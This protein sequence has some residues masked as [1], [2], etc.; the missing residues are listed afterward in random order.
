MFRIV[1]AGLS[2]D[3]RQCLSSPVVVEAVDPGSNLELVAGLADVG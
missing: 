2:I 1:G 3:L